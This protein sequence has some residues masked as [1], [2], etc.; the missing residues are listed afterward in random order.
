[1]KLHTLRTF[2]PVTVN[3][4]LTLA[5][6]LALAVFFSIPAHAQSGIWQVDAE[7]SIARLSLGRAP[8][9]AEV[10]LA[11]VS[12][13]V[14]FDSN[15]SA[16]PSDPISD[17][18]IASDKT[19]GPNASE[20]SFKSKRSVISKDGKLAVVGDLSI[21]RLERSVT[22]DANEAYHGA[23]YADPLVYTETHEVTLVFPGT[24]LPAAQNGA[25]KLSASTIINR[26]DFPQ[27]LAALQS[28]NWPSVVVEDAN[29]TNPSTI[30]EGY[31]GAICSGT[32][33]TTA[34]NSVPPANVGGEG[35]SGFEPAV[36]PDGNHATIALNLTLTQSA[37]ASA[38]SGLSVA[39]ESAGH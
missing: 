14:V 3:L 26:E 15:D 13:S 23:E 10:G 21:R 31:S 9:S 11:A 35:Y 1:M 18:N 33:V 36:V 12:G 4:S 30:G 2:Q 7:H 24:S 34:T 38:Q 20:I 32:T 16:D 28:D 17:V 19:L 5:L 8:Q 29:C 37:P 39:A 6:L 22:M 25:I 27:L